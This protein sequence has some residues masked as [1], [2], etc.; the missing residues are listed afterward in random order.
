MIHQGVEKSLFLD[1][2]VCISGTKHVEVGIQHVKS[3]EMYKH[4]FYIL[5]HMCD[6]RKCRAR[7]NVKG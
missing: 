4:N 5:P 7:F 1:L 2:M 6:F 3:A